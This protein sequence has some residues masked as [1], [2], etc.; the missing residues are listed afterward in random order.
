MID[1]KEV[2]RLMKCGMSEEEAIETIKYDEMVENGEKTDFDLTPE[3]EKVSKK[4]RST[5]T[6]KTTVYTFTK[7]E[8]KPNEEKRLIISELEQFIRNCVK[9]SV[10]GL[11]VSNPEKMIDFTIND[12]SYSIS[13]INHRKPKE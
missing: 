8:R 13:L 4:A 7:R 10:E 6:K 12:N 3:Q 2:E 9:L 11:T 5:G 1:R